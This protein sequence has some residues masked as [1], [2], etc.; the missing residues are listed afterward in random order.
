MGAI[1][2]ITGVMG[3]ILYIRTMMGCILGV[4]AVIGYILG[5]RAMRLYTW[6]KRSAVFFICITSIYLI[7]DYPAHKALWGFPH[8]IM[9]HVI[10]I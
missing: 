10:V 6:C 5:V 9:L 3:C 4:R 1:R 2:G 7:E 8:I